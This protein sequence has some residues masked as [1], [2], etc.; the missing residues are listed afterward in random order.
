[1]QIEII[2]TNTCPPDYPELVRRSKAFGAFSARIHLDVSDG[3]FTPIPHGLCLKISGVRLKNGRA[4]GNV[5]ARKNCTLRSAYDVQEPLRLGTH[6]ARVGC[7]RII[8][9][10]E[11]LT[12]HIP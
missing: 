1:M 12:V 2:P 4:S 3:K 5:T 8:A 6:M 9:H 7:R 10:L 11:T